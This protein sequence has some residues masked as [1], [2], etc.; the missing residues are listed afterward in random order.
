MMEKDK[1]GVKLRYP[2]REC[3]KCKKYPCFIGFDKCKCNF[4][5]YGCLLY[6]GT[7]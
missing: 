4:P 7:G 2:D 3:T 6:D 5:A 1:D